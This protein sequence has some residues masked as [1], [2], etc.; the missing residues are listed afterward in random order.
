MIASLTAWKQF[1]CG[2]SE[3]TETLVKDKGALEGLTDALA[4][5]SDAIS[6]DLALNVKEVAKRLSE[7]VDNHAAVQQVSCRGRRR[8]QN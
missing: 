4:I 2:L 3:F 8:M 7:K 1:E 5:E 6:S